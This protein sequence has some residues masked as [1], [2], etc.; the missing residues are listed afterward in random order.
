M[1][2]LLSLKLITEVLYTVKCVP[3]NVSLPTTYGDH[4]C[5]KI[6][7]LNMQNMVF[8]TSNCRIDHNSINITSGLE[9]RITN[10]CIVQ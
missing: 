2:L 4:I 5:R 10:E 1:R 8:F 3:F 6:L 7:F 9:V